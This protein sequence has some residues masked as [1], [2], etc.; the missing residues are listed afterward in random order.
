MTAPRIAIVILNWNGMADTMECLAS[1]ASIDYPDF[2][3]VVVD[4][5]STDDSVAAVREAFPSVTLLETGANLGYAGGNNAG[6]RWALERGFDG[7]LVLNNDTVVDKD[8]LH[9]FA[10]AQQRFPE[11]GVFGAKICYYAQPEVLWFA[12]GEWRPHMLEFGHVG[13]DLR[14]SAEYSEPRAFD[15]MTGC[16][17][18][19]SAEVFRRVGL[20]AEEF[21][22]TFE[23]TDWC[24]RARKLGFAP[25]YIPDA[26]LWHKV[27]VSFG[28]ESSALAAYFMT[29]NRLHFVRRHMPTRTLFHLLHKEARQ[30][31]KELLPYPKSYL[32]GAW[33]S[34]RRFF[35]AL[36]TYRQE[37]RRRSRQPRTQAR[38]LGFRDFLLGRLGNCPEVVRS[39]SRPSQD[40]TGHERETVADPAAQ[41]R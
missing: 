14:D 25:T 26:R 30:F 29:R 35:R 5:G 13:K 16:A 40:S 24:Y 41:A 11:A 37:V 15:Y 17:L 34:P 1:V 28:G 7:V 36:G 32:A 19:A 10:A 3:V 38:L 12:G 27:S 31:G 23:E 39:S 8:L 6:I 33:R 21:F 18:Y 2:R 20:F 9:A 22:L 4:N